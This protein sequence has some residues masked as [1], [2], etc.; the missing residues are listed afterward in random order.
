MT[1]LLYIFLLV[2]LSIKLNGQVNETKTSIPIKDRLFLSGP[3][4]SS[5]CGQIQ[6]AYQYS[7]NFYGVQL[8]KLSTDGEIGFSAVSASALSLL[9]GK[10]GGQNFYSFDANY[11]LG[12]FPYTLVFCIG[13]GSSFITNFDS[14]NFLSIY[15][16]IHFDIGGIELSYHY[17]FKVLDNLQNNFSK[18]TFK[19]SLGL[20]FWKKVKND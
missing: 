12:L 8:K 17:K 13:A 2:L 18:H 5:F 15:P 14:Q 6:Y 20:R 3:Y 10:I 7:N 1:K 9:Y 4:G 16:T 11:H 19:L